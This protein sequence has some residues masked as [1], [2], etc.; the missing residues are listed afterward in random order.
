MNSHKIDGSSCLLTK[1]KKGSLKVNIVD[2]DSLIGD[3]EY[4]FDKNQG[5]TVEIYD[6]KIRNKR[7]KRKE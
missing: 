7:D 2:I 1:E 6:N 5:E 3:Y 4:E